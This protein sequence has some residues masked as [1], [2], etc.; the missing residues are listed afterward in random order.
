MRV[1]RGERF[2][3]AEWT[4]EGTPPPER[5]PGA[6][7]GHIKEGSSGPVVFAVVASI[8]AIVL[9]VLLVR[10]S[11]PGGT[12]KGLAATAADLSA[13]HAG[14]TVAGAEVRKLTRVAV[15]Q[16][17]ATDEDGRARLRLDDGT[18]IVLDRAT[19]LSLTDKGITLARGR[20]FVEGAPG[21]RTEI[22]LGEATALI[23]GAVAA[24][25]R[26]RAP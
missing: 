2:D 10:Q 22:G 20:I 14:V 7:L 5:E 15:G 8:A 13:V 17:V 9:T 23:S 1:T 19:E 18:A 3:V 6:G 4:T 16:T 21:A 24:A 12:S 25:E 11:S 26:G